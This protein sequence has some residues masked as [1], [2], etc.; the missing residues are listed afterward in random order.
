MTARMFAAAL[1]LLL[2]YA[3]PT[4][5]GVDRTAVGQAAV[6]DRLHDRDVGAQV[7]Q[8]RVGGAVPASVPPQ[9]VARL[10]C[11]EVP[12]AREDAAAVVAVYCASTFGGIEPGRHELG[13]LSRRLRRLRRLI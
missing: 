11:E 7:A 9:E 1:S 6:A 3:V 13:E 4:H 10:F 12:A 5:A 2:T 8:Q